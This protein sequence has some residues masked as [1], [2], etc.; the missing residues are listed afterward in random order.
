MAE[1]G[2]GI[3]EA[4]GL[5]LLLPLCTSP[6]SARKE[7]PLSDAAAAGITQRG[8]LLAEYDFA[9]QRAKDTVT[10][11]NPQPGSINHYVARKD[12]QTQKWTV[13]FGRFSEDKQ[14]FLVVY[15]VDQGANPEGFS[16]RKNE[17]PV[18]DTSFYF[19]SAKAIDTAVRDFHGAQRPYNAAVLPADSSG[20][21]VYIVPAQTRPDE[22]PL[23]GDARYLISADGSA[24]IEARQLHK[25]IL[26]NRGSVPAG[27]KGAGGVHSHVLSDVPEDTDIA[28]VLTRKPS[29][30]EFIG[31][32]KHV[33]E[34]QVDGTIRVQ[35]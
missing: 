15:E 32:G 4:I 26:E 19:F 17:P 23:G 21:Y 2:V 18:E 1:T 11:M 6:G 27:A 24:V 9:A 25:T 31:A 33:Y 20:L 28:Y 12:A 16:V 7:S 14:E 5:S 13:A 22:Y 35:K 8:R 10:A 3:R 30:P 29:G 34:N